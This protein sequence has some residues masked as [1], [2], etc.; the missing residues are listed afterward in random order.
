ME[1]INTIIKFSFIGERKSGG[2]RREEAALKHKKKH[3]HNQV[4]P[5]K[6]L[7]RGSL[8]VSFW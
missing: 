3:K 4:K 2:R 5:N 7:R 1:K 8:N 6:S